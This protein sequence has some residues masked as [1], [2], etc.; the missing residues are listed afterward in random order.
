M[1]THVEIL[2]I[3]VNS[4]ADEKTAVTEYAVP[5]AEDRR[6]SDPFT[7][8]QV[9][10]LVHQV[11]FPSSGK[12]RRQIIFSAVDDDVDV[13]GVCTLVA[14]S[15]S[16]RVG[17]TVALVDAHACSRDMAANPACRRPPERVGQTGIRAKSNQLSGNLWSVPG[18]V[19][20]G[21]EPHAGSPAWVRTRL[22]ELRSEFDYT[23]IHAPA[24]G[25]YSGTCL[26]GQSSDGLVLI[27]EANYTRRSTAQKAK[28][29]LHIANVRVLGTVLSGRTFP[30]PESIYRKL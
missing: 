27:I 7:A 3:P 10:G 26:L 13:G 24:A 11:F 15:L 17:E 30:I 12:L 16:S 2:R 18:P 1:S 22:G 23:L 14:E 4:A 20:W 9:Q 5:V 29:K 25:I 6:V 8:E 19:F 21:N 28:E